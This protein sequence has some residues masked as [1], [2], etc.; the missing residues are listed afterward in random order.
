MLLISGVLRLAGILQKQPDLQFMA[1]EFIA[2]QGDFRVLLMGPEV[3]IIHR[4]SQGD[5]HLN[6]TSVGGQATLIPTNDFPT[7]VIEESRKFAELCEYEIS[8]VDVIFDSSTNKHYFL[9]INSQPQLMTGA[10]V[11]LKSHMLC[12][13]FSQVLGL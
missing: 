4:Q 5:S 9:E 6:N 11:P 13:Y 3:A 12:S 10:E 7:E 1:Q 8:G 2:N